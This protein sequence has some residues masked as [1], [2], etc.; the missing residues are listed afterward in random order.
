MP[1]TLQ[2]WEWVGAIAVSLIAILA[3]ARPLVAKFW[4]FLTAP[5]R[6]FLDEVRAMMLRVARIDAR[7][8]AMFAASA[9]PAFE[10]NAAG[11]FT[12]V[13]RAFEALTGYSDRDL[14][15]F[16]WVNV[17]HQN[18]AD[19][20]MEEWQHMVRHS[21]ILRRTVRLMTQQKTGIEV[22]VDTQPMRDGGIDIGWFGTV[23]PEGSDTR[24]RLDKLERDVIIIRREKGH[25]PD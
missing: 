10:A 16:R 5:V 8:S 11:E 3:A 14:L 17:I 25:G 15:G 20:F 22:R 1:Q 23:E 6:T 19:D 7:N 9:I 21:R 24:G 4:M 2:E 13:N 18:D 12:M